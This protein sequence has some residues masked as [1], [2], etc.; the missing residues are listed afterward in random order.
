MN[1]EFI[2]NLFEHSLN[3]HPTYF[4][5][6]PGGAH[7]HHTP[8]Y[9]PLILSSTRP[10]DRISRPSR[11]STRNE[12]VFVTRRNLVVMGSNP[13]H[14]KILK[15]KMVVRSDMERSTRQSLDVKETGR[16]DHCVG[17]LPLKRQLPVVGPRVPELFQ[18]PTDDPDGGFCCTLSLFLMLKGCSDG[19]RRSCVDERLIVSDSQLSWGPGYG[20]VSNYTTT[21]YHQIDQHFCVTYRQ[22]TG[23]F[24]RGFYHVFV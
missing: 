13:S 18:S 4:Q 6:S 7:P 2:L 3:I 19:V 20:V 1:Y 21:V 16:T 8:G 10:L 17:S 9:T 12:V 23:G 24:C 14:Q 15:F 11:C 5:H 22:E